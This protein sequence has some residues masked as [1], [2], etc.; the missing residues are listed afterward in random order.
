MTF[1]WHGKLELGDP[2]LDQFFKNASDHLR[3]RALGYMGRSLQDVDGQVSP[4]TLERLTALWQ[5]RVVT[6]DADPQ[7]HTE[8]MAAFGQWFAS[9][10]FDEAWALDELESSLKISGK[11]DFDHQVVER[12]A[13]WSQEFPAK[14]VRC[15][16]LMVDGAREDWRIHHWSRHITLVLSAALGS[17]DEETK[18]I[19]RAMI[20]RLAT[21][22]FLDF[23]PL[24]GDA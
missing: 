2:L 11:V 23:A 13:D 24:L 20:N 15:L 8:E 16:S 14:I 7:E 4:E 5:W 9:N 1:Y 18:K 6:S 12:L 21:R 17:S 3:G 19:A 22:G 10:K